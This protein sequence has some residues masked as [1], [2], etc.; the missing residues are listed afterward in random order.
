MDEFLCASLRP[1]MLRKIA[2][3]VSK[4]S[5][6]EGFELVSKACTDPKPSPEPKEARGSVGSEAVR[7]ANAMGSGRLDQGLK[8]R[9]EGQGF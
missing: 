6:F 4:P 3:L 2:G 5:C 8:G 1:I 7:E 9:L